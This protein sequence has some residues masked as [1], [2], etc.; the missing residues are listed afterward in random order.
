[1]ADVHFSK[2]LGNED[3]SGSIIIMMEINLNVCQHGSDDVE[4]ETTGYHSLTAHR[5]S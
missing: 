3:Q 5:M 2:S 4:T 1:M